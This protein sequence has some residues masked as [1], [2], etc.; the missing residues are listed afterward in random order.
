MRRLRDG[1]RV[2]RA[3]CTT[4]W[5]PSSPKSRVPAPGRRGK[6]GTREKQVP[7]A[8]MMHPARHEDI[9]AAPLIPLFSRQMQLIS[10]QLGPLV[11]KHPLQNPSEAT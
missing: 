9:R 10:G 1:G 7:T 3:A 6:R 5:V 4:A 11:E 8:P 2:E